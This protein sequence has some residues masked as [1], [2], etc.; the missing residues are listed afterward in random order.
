MTSIADPE[1]IDQIRGGNQSAW[2]TIIDRYEGR[3]LAFVDSRVRNR[4]ISED[5]VQETFLGFLVSLPN[6]DIKTPLES[7]L[8][9]IAG[10]KL[11]DHF[12][13]SGRRPTFSFAGTPS[14]PGENDL[15]GSMRAPSSMLRSGERK[16][17]EEA[18]LRG[19]LAELI[20]HWKT[21]GEWERLQCVELLFVLGWKNKDVAQRLQLSEQDVANHKAFVMG[22]LKDAVQ[23]AKLPGF[24]LADFVIE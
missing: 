8:F 5:L 7:W 18:V 22:K 24:R 4:A 19:T 6:Y 23:Q 9:S 1:L 12:R 10:Y 11:T 14:R 17:A 2:K 3:L 16:S 13:K 15:A 20:Q 21:S